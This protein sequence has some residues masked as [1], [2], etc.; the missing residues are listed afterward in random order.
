MNK[1]HGSGMTETTLSLSLASCGG[2]QHDIRVEPRAI[3][4]VSLVTAFPKSRNRTSAMRTS[5]RKSLKRTT[6]LI[7]TYKQDSN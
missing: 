5:T 4:F 2:M 1:L 6:L 7:P 3:Y